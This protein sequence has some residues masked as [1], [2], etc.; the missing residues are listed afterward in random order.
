MGCDNKDRINVLDIGNNRSALVTIEPA[1]SIKC[2][3][4]FF[5]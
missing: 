2:G 4:F 5:L 3:K 1:G